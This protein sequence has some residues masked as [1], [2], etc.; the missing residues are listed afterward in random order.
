MILAAEWVARYGFGCR[1][2]TSCC[3]SDCGLSNDGYCTLY[4]NVLTSQYLVFD[5]FNSC[6]QHH[7][8]QVH[9][10]HGLYWLWWSTWNVSRSSR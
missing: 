4:C 2:Y 6:R 7:G 5:V 1:H 8:N 3:C 10:Q 9:W